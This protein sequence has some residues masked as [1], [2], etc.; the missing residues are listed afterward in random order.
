M[1]IRHRCFFSLRLFAARPSPL[2]QDGPPATAAGSAQPG[3]AGFALLEG[4]VSLEPAGVDQFSAAEINYPLT[5][6]DRIYADNQALGELQTSGLALRLGN[7]ADLTVTTLNDFTAQFGLAQGS[8]RL[9]T[10]D[11]DAPPTGGW[12]ARAGRRRNRYQP[13][14]PSSFERPGDIRVDSY[15]QDDTTI[16]TVTTGQVEVTGNG[17][18]QVLYPGPGPAPGRQPHLCSKAVQP[19]SPDPLDRFDF[20]RERARQ[21]SLAISAQYVDPGH[22][23]RGRPRPV[24]RL[25][26]EQRSSGRYERRRLV[27]SRLVSALR[28]LRLDVPT[29]TAT[30]PGWCR[31][32]G[33]GSRPSHGGSRPSTMAAGPSSGARA[34]GA[35]GA[36]SPGPPR[37][38]S[39]P[40][41]DA[42]STPSTRPRWWRSSAG[43]RLLAS[44]SASVASRVAGVTA[45]FPLG[46][47]EAFVPWYHASPGYV[48]RVNV[49]NLYN[50]NVAEVHNT[51]INRT[52]VVYN[53]TVNNTYVNRTPGHGGRA[54]A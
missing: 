45:W 16:V 2:A 53:T 32:A 38:L 21:Q 33:P 1:H 4:N 22:D 49:T 23:R 50:R 3:G 41:A 26:P 35:D 28:A 19:L 12:Q 27:R 11:L 43:L 31:G 44:R 34:A 18:D 42:P 46:P 30:G 9:R 47:R 5:A 40:P 54:S 24:R 14:A 13:T 10:R 29:R 6:G 52:T 51:Y 15:P 48:N 39:S 20:E 37:L 8:L 7:G 17:V 36:G 25:G